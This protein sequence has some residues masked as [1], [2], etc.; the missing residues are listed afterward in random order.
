MPQISRSRHTRQTNTDLGLLE[1]LALLVVGAAALLC[2]LPALVIGLTAEQLLRDRSWSTPLWLALAA[3]G[4]GTTAF[5]VL[6]GPGQL[7]FA[8][9]STLLHEVHA[10]Q[11]N[12]LQWDYARIWS[13]TWPVWLETLVLAPVIAAFRVLASQMHHGGA[14]TL[15]NQER[16]RQQGVERAQRRAT[17]RLRHPHRFPDAIRGQMVI[18][19][20]I[21]D[22][23]NR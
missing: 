15:L 5:L 14:A 3:L 21:E 20:P 7:V 17:R 22:E 10:H 13:K 2:A 23:S 1:P 8:Q 18:G 4:L 9:L 6:H 11:A 16:L 19:V 12:L